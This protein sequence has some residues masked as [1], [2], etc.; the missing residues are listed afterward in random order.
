MG[1]A[2]TF[3]AGYMRV[4]TRR[5]HMAQSAR[6]LQFGWAWAWAWGFVST[7]W[8]TGVEAGEQCFC[9]CPTMASMQGG[10]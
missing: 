9:K 2:L 4:A 7:S 1:G 3:C 8:L 5:G 10:F 6:A